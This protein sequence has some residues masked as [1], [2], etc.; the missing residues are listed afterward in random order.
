MCNRK[1]EAGT[2]YGEQLKLEVVNDHPQPEVINRNI[3][4]GPEM[5]D[6]MQEIYRKY[7]LAIRM[8]QGRGKYK[9]ERGIEGERKAEKRGGREEGNGNIEK[10]GSDTQSNQNW[11][12]GKM[13]EM[14]IKAVGVE[15][16]Q[17]VRR[18]GQKARYLENHELDRKDNEIWRFPKGGLQLTTSNKNEE[19]N[20]G[21]PLSS[22]SGFYGNPKCE[23]L[24]HM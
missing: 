24:Q 3:N 23:Y 5:E 1:Q 2:G 21:P 14:L 18:N 15:K 17:F 20:F 7:E 13:R 11:L 8:Q 22:S 12:W 6:L 4:L 19:A 9:N 10:E 16:Q